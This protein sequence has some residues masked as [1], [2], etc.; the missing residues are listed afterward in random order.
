[1]PFA[2]GL[3]M[4]L[5]VKQSRKAAESR[6]VT[7]PDDG[8]G[9]FDSEEAAGSA[10]RN[11]AT[12]LVRSSAPDEEALAPFGSERTERSPAPGRVDAG[13]RR[14]RR[15]ETATAAA[16]V[17]TSLA[18][19][20]HS[21]RVPPQQREEAAAATA[22]NVVMQLP[23]HA[24]TS[25]E[26]RDSRVAQAASTSPASTIPQAP[27]APQAHLSPAPAPSASVGGDRAAVHPKPLERSL[28]TPPP[29]ARVRRTTIPGGTAVPLILET[30]ISPGA[31]A[32]DP[33]RARVAHHVVVNK[34]VLIPRGT[35]LTGHV[36]EARRGSRW[37]SGLKFWELG[38][39]QPV[40][41]QFTRMRINEVTQ[42]SY[43]IRTEV[44]TARRPRAARTVAVPAAFATVGGAMIAGPLGAAG[45]GLTASALAGSANSA[46]VPRGTKVS[47]R[48]VEA[49]VVERS[50][51]SSRTS[52][53][54][55]ARRAG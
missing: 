18:L 40:R 27:P 17:L 33:V 48:L 26:E 42:P 2:S 38:R 37:A 50:A 4:R 55:A 14:A 54:S 1:M 7:A 10:A 3:I 8:L 12:S 30:V 31:R 43:A 36:V 41:L 13:H 51:Y 29:A 49:V 22:S 47:A 9:A 16:V 34:Q 45:G 32:G 35:I 44:V 11:S 28:A 39:G 15:W 6:V 23:Q 25:P 5:W 52:S 20:W 46:A 53:R 21:L 19:S 24:N